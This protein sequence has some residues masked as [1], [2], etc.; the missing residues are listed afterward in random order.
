[1]TM[2]ML[3][4]GCLLWFI[5]HSSYI[6]QKFVIWMPIY[7]CL[8]M[9]F[10]SMHVFSLVSFVLLLTVASSDVNYVL[11][12]FDFVFFIFLLILF[13]SSVGQMKPL[14]HLHPVVL[15]QYCLYMLC[16][17]CFSMIVCIVCMVS[18]FI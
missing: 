4:F 6:L 16:F 9:Q 11:S 3:A 14:L 18:Q 10:F 5:V 13:S 17:V 1:M 8:I 2:S 7:L 12:F 15:F